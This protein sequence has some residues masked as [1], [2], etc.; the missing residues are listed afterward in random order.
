VSEH[1]PLCAYDDGMLFYRQCVCE[2]VRRAEQRGRD[3]VAQMWD[4]DTRTFPGR[5]IEAFDRGVAEEKRRIR[6]E[7]V[8]YYKVAPKA[9]EPIL[10]IIDA[11]QTQ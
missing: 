3:A 6:S 10:R 4:A 9:A 2:P 8:D 7:V 1:D 11:T 5:I